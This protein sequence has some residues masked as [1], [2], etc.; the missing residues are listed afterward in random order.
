MGGRAQEWAECASR[1]TIKRKET[2][3]FGS[4]ED[5]RVTLKN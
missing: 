1:L 2:P 3:A 5:M 4:M